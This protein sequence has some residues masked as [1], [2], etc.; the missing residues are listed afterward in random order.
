MVQSIVRGPRATAFL[1]RLSPAGLKALEPHSSTLS[2]LLNPE[3]GI[4][5]DLIITRLKEDE[6]Y[7]VTNAGRRDRDLA[8]F[9]DVQK[10]F[11][12]GVEI[13]V[14]EEHG[15]I[16]L[17]GPKAAAVLQSLT[18]EDLTKLTFG[19]SA[20]LNLDGI[21][22]QVHVA[23]GRYTGEDGFEVSAHYKIIELSLTISIIDIYFTFTD[24]CVG[25]DIA[26]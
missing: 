14:L 26:S 4:I 1:E 23:R 8:W 12:D 19:H 17:Q 6:Y 9:K 2:V 24:S 22:G 21:E 15:L 16:A 10:Q 13:E 5:D 3:G 7:V 18:K 25:R 20:Y 11:Q